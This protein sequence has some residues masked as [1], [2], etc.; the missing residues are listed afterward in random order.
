MHHIHTPFYNYKTNICFVG[1]SVDDTEI[2]NSI[3]KLD[4]I[5]SFA[6]KWDD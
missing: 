4:Q 5:R 2:Q 1:K 3:L 6:I